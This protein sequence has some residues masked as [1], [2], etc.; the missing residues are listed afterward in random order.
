VQAFR[1]GIVDLPEDQ[2]AATFNAITMGDGVTEFDIRL[3]EPN[4][5]F[6]CDLD[7]DSSKP[8]KAFV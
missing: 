2:A 8:S 1:P 4:L 3:P 5:D 6:R 7:V